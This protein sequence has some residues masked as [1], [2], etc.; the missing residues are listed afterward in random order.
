MSKHLH[1]KLAVL[2]QN[3]THGKLPR[4]VPW[5]DA[6]SLISHLGR[7]EP[8]TND[9]FTF[10]IGES[11]EVFKR[12][13]SHQLDMDDVSRLRKLV[14]AGESA[15]PPPGLTPGGGRMIVVI[16]HA[17]AHV[18]EDVGAS[19]PREIASLSPVDPHHFHHH[20]IHKKESH[21][22]GDRVP[23]DVPFYR[24]IAETLIPATEIVIIGHGVGK[25]SAAS[26]LMEYLRSHRPD[27]AK[28]VQ[29]QEV[30]DLSALTQP[31][32]EDLARPHFGV[33]A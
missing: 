10:V 24:A 12:P 17:V 20:L 31:Q 33:I 28:L 29:A 4:D 18:Y 21:Y 30:A 15:G 7:V 3:L 14:Q 23:E 9:E 27:I 32:I 22:Q 13:H 19:R 11:V 25:S 26:V 1:H 2:R 16:D 5:D 6:V 8:G